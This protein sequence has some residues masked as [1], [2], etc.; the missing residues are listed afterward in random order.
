MTWQTTGYPNDAD[1]IE[2]WITAPPTEAL[3]LKRPLP[4]GSLQIVARL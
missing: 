4:G 3:K 2:T 1:V